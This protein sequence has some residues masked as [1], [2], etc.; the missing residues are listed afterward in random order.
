MVSRSLALRPFVWA[1]MCPCGSR[2]TALW[3]KK[4]L[5]VTHVNEPQNVGKQILTPYIT[6]KR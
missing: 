1:T 2:T 6:L 3:E 4:V 5:R